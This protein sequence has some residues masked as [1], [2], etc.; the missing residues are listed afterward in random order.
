MNEKEIRKPE[1]QK[2]MILAGDDLADTAIKEIADQ[3]KLG[4]V[5]KMLSGLIRNDEITSIMSE[6]E[7]FELS[8]S[9][10]DTEKY[11]TSNQQL[12]AAKDVGMVL[13]NYLI[14]SGTLPEALGPLD[15]DLLRISEEIF[16]QYAMTAFS[17]LGCA[18]LPEAYASTYASRVLATTQ[19]LQT[20]LQ[21]RISETTLFVINVM[22]KDGLNPGGAG[23]KAAQKVRLMHA[24]MRYLLLQPPTA[25]A[26]DSAPRDLGDV[27]RQMTWPKELGV[28]IHQLSMSMAILSFSYIVLRSLKKLGIDLSPI[29]EKA[30]LY[31]W[32]V[33]AHVMGVQPELLL[34][35]P[36]TMEQAEQMYEAIWPPAVAE[37]LQ[38]RALEKALLDYLEGFVPK[39]L[40]RLTRIPRILT[41]ELI[42]PKMARVLDINLGFSDNLGLQTMKAMTGLHRYGRNLAN[43]L[44]IS[45]DWADNA[46]LQLMKGAIGLDHLNIDSI[47]EFPPIRIAA[48]WLFRQMARQLNT[49][50]R[51]GN[52]APFQIPDTLTKPLQTNPPLP[53]P[54]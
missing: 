7:L 22:S 34:S 15:A 24:A 36:I 12:Q 17:I 51:G 49:M 4:Q 52:R 19:Q 44:G 40:G 13:S 21:R 23:M 31:R 10:V 41:R 39:A 29:Q 25:T 48:E 37:T 8:P 42:G 30:Y 53:E 47:D 20:H 32:N 16:A 26:P 9:F 38:G 2:R 5:T 46:G 3:H 6:D 14:K 27:L 1:F 28:P 43:V 35:D 54:Q 18:S 50:Q 45:V 33:I 11:K